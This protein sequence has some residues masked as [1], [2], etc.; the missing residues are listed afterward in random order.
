MEEGG[1]YSFLSPVVHPSHLSSVA[2][3]NDFLQTTRVS[4]AMLSGATW[5][6]FVSHPPLMNHPPQSPLDSVGVTAYV[7]CLTGLVGAV[8]TQ[9][10]YLGGIFPKT[11]GNSFDAPFNA[12]I[13]NAN[14]I[15]VGVGFDFSASGA[16]LEYQ[17]GFPSGKSEFIVG[18]HDS[19]YQE[20][21][22][23]GECLSNTP[24]STTAALMI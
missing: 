12:P 21:T 15:P 9:R 6:V 23:F 24:F 18:N 11:Y 14:E 10:A 4:G 2:Q 17:G 13:C 20:F 7:E 1:A 22:L 19:S 3:G 5:E 8:V 16:L